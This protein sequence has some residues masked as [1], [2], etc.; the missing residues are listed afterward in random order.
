MNVGA[1]S[2][3]LSS[4]DRPAPSTALRFCSAR[5]SARSGSSAARSNPTE[6]FATRIGGPGASGENLMLTDTAASSEPT[7]PPIAASAAT[8][9]SSNLQHSSI[10]AFPRVGLYAGR[11]GGGGAFFQ[12]S[13]S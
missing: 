8:A 6:R 3:R 12:G 11:Q 2:W 4:R 7:A 13:L 10:T 9:S 1:D 5:R